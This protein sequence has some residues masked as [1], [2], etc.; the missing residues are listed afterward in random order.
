MLNDTDPCLHP[1]GNTYTWQ[2]AVVTF[3]SAL[4]RLHETV[5]KANT[6]YQSNCVGP[7]GALATGGGN[8][9]AG[10]PG[11]ELWGAAEFE[12]GKVCSLLCFDPLHQGVR[13][14]L[15]MQ[16]DGLAGGLS[17]CTH[18]TAVCPCSTKAAN[19]LFV[20]LHAD[21]RECAIN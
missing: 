12:R 11:W 2:T 20:I 16:Q 8:S 9:M 6:N 17:V 14:Q 10:R 1:Q 19:N 7:V 15:Q 3:V 18:D 13:I 5:S 4:Q 21:S